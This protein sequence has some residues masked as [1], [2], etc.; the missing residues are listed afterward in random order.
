MMLIPNWPAP[1]NI[2]AYT[3]T[4]HDSVD[5]LPLKLHLLNQVHGSDMVNLP[6]P[7]LV[8]NADGAYT[9]SMNMPCS[10]RTADCLAIFLC[11]PQGT[12]IA[13]LHAGWR[14]LAQGIIFQGIK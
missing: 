14:G 9:Q 6:N 2:T 8:L 5:D 1:K 4:K 13:A 12:E 11:N 10:I 3:L 7:M